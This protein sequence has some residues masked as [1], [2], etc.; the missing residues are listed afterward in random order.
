MSECRRRKSLESFESYGRTNHMSPQ[1][2][3]KH[4]GKFLKKKEMI[5]IHQ[6]LN[7]E[8]YMG[9]LKSIKH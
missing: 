1:K 8:F 4:R 3:R 9:L 6:V 2:S 5:N 7:Q